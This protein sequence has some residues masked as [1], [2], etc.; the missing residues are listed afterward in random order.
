[1]WPGLPSRVTHNSTHHGTTSTFALKVVSGSPRTLRTPPSAPDHLPGDPPQQVQEHS[2]AR[3]GRY[4][5]AGSL[6]TRGRSPSLDQVFRDTMEAIV[7]R[8]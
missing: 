6:G 8:I 4:A 5:L 3:T 2:A 7:V 1:M